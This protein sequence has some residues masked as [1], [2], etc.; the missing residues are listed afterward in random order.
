M[1]DCCVLVVVFLFSAPTG[2]NTWNTTRL[3]V[4]FNIENTT[5]VPSFIEP[6]LF[7]E[8]QMH[9]SSAALLMF[10]SAAAILNYEVWV[11]VESLT[12]GGVPIENSNWKLGN[13]NFTL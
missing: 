8:S 3:F 13:Y 7:S 11:G 9:N 6:S 12:W 2:C 5:A 10:T 1:D 4:F